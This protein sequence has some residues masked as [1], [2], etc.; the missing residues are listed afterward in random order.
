MAKVL[1]DLALLRQ[2][3]NL[4]FGERK[5][6]DKASRLLIQEI[7]FAKDTDEQSVEG[8]INLLFTAVVAAAPPPAAE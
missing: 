2:D 5:M 3:K 1:R 4:S 6:F 7:A 8:E